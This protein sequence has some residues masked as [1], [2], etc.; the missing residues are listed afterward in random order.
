MV[1][2]GFSQLKIMFPNPW[3]SS[4]GLG[5][6]TSNSGQLSIFIINFRSLGQS[7]GQ[8]L[9]VNGVFHLNKQFV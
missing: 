4:S 2:Q 7:F 5:G 3:V 9:E 1:F 8:H 6:D